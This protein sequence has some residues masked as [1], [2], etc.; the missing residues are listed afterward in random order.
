MSSRQAAQQIAS[1]LTQAGVPAGHSLDVAQR[2]L[3][4][5]NAGPMQAQ[6][7]RS[8]DANSANNAEFYNR[9]KADEQASRDS[10]AGKAGKDGL[11]GY[12]G[13]GVDGRDGIPGVPGVQGEI[14]WD[15]I[16]DMIAQMIQEALSAF[17]TNLLTNVLNCTWFRRKLRDCV[18][19]APGNG[20][21]SAGCSPKCCKG[22][23]AM[24]GMSICSILN[25]HATTLGQH[26]RRLKKIEK[27]LAETTD[28]EA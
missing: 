6:G 7:S 17:L 22:E 27:D 28:C 5:A 24:S 12:G 4:M 11:P 1:L 9:H 13:R 21:T 2:L 20:G 26:E 3:S 16:R 19:S 18:E 14:N 10:A 8:I 23:G 25:K 15:N